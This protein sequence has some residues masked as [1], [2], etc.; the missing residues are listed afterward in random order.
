MIHHSDVPSAKP[1]S[2]NEQSARL[3]S[4]SNSTPATDTVRPLSKTAA[5]PR[6]LATALFN[7]GLDV[8]LAATVSFVMWVSLLLHVAF[9]PATAAAGWTLWGWTFDQWRNA[10]FASLSI[11]FLL[12][13][14]HVVLHWTWVCGVVTT[15]VLRLKKRPDEAVQKL[16]GIGFFFGL[17]LIG[18]AGILAAA[19]TVKS[20]SP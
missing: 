20:P 4:S 15:K 9:P 17:M 3:P 14:E 5:P 7:L 6:K 2:D 19:L 16:Y 18:F 12:I 8:I 1:P 11:L 10:Q 13:V